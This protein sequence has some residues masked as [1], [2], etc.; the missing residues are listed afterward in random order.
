MD[1]RTDIK[2]DART[3]AKLGSQRAGSA[4]TYRV[5]HLN[6]NSDSLH[7]SACRKDG[8]LLMVASDSP[9]KTIFYELLILVLQSYLLIQTYTQPK[10]MKSPIPRK[11]KKNAPFKKEE[12]NLIIQPMAFHVPQCLGRYSHANSCNAHKNAPRQG[13]SMRFYALLTN[14]KT[15]GAS[16][17]NWKQT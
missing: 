8:T 10:R 17:E 5:F 7:I 6:W 12:E 14:L 16:R 2:R 11:R 13:S 9:W 1:G 4:L 15:V 3:A